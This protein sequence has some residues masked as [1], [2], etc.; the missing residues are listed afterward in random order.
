MKE[1]RS[2]QSE[3]FTKFLQ[4]NKSVLSNP[5]VKSFLQQKENVHLL[6]KA[7]DYPTKENKEKVDESFKKHYFA[8]RFTSYITSSMEYSTINF[9]KSVRMIQE[10]FPLFLAEK[11]EGR[12]KDFLLQDEAAEIETIVERE[13]LRS[14][15]EEYITDET[16]YAA[17]LDLT[18]S[19]RTILTYAYLYQ[20]TDT[21]IARTIGTSQQ[22]V[23]KARKTALK[24]ILSYMNRRRKENGISR[25]D[26]MDDND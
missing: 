5:V 15:M 20:W 3:A 23:S 9:N 19:Q 6:K 18:N 10:R 8:I 7:I 1:W 17:I 11:E 2:S 12:E 21:E 26:S 24:R 14:G 13:S 4:E 16:I 25:H 22:Y